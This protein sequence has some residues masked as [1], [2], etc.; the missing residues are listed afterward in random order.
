MFLYVLRFIQCADVNALGSSKTPAVLHWNCFTHST[1]CFSDRLARALGG[2]F[3][4]FHYRG[5]FGFG[6]LV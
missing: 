6:H 4:F 2:T 1:S 3:G 5:P